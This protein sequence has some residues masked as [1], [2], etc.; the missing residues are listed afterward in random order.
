M[1]GRARLVRQHGHGG[2]R[3]GRGVPGRR[4]APLPHPGGAVHRGHRAH[5]RAVADRRARTGPRAARRR[6]RTVRTRWSTCWWPSTPG[7]CSGP[8][9]TCGWRPPTRRR[10]GRGSAA[11]ESRIGR[12]A[13][14]LAV[15]FLGADESL[16]GVQGDRA[17][18]PGHGPRPGPGQSAQRRLGAP[19]PDRPAVVPDAGR[20]AARGAGRRVE[21]AGRAAEVRAGQ[22]RGAGSRAARRSVQGG[23]RR[24]GGQP[25]EAD[26][27]P[28]RCGEQ[29]NRPAR[30]SAAGS[31]QASRT[32]RHGPPSQRARTVTASPALLARTVTSA[33]GPLGYRGERPVGRAVGD[34]GAQLRCAVGDLDARLDPGARRRTR[35]SAPAWS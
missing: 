7:R 18:H 1:P 31:S 13:H 20:G 3:P 6:A 25:G 11:L 19:G 15:E 17:G 26:G 24:A 35:T 9:C 32:M 8:P 21:P 28:A 16:P 22:E 29:Q 23:V 10:C 12:E 14:R 2:V 33:A 34:D 27:S 4:P 30:A 5:G